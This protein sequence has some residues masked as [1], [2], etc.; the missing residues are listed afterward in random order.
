[1]MFIKRLSGLATIAVLILIILGPRSAGAEVMFDNTE[2]PF[3]A[4]SVVGG[5]VWSITEDGTTAGD[6]GNAVMTKQ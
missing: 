6:V 4:T 2:S 1:M 5:F 3:R